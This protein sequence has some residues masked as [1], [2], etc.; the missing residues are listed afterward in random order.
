MSSGKAEYQ[1]PIRSNMYAKTAQKQEIQ[2]HTQGRGPGSLIHVLAVDR[3]RIWA[4]SWTRNVVFEFG[5][6]ITSAPAY[7]VHA[8]TLTPMS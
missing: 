4:S 5:A 7:G 1:G 6:V 3:L 2:R 8:V